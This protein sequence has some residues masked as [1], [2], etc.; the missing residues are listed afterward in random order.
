MAT[1]PRH[2]S[3]RPGFVLNVDRQTPPLLF[4]HGDNFRL[5]KLP[6]D[7]TRVIY[8][9]E[10]LPGLP[11]PEAAIRHA[12]LE[13]IDDDPLPELLKP[14]MKLTIAFDDIS[15]PLPSMRKP[16]IRHASSS[17]FSI[18]PQQPVS[19]MFTSSL[20]WRCIAA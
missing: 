10:P 9:A 11:D 15:L 20:R 16:D 12:L 7:R 19:M 8:P 6:A 4:H 17:R 18:W 13:L 14:G 3:P 1:D 5:E 2:R